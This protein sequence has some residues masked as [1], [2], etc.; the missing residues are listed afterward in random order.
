M[1]HTGR[2]WKLQVIG[3]LSVVLAQVGLASWFVLT[4]ASSSSMVK[5]R[6][7]D[8]SL[9]TLL[10]RQDQEDSRVVPLPRHD[11]RWV[12]DVHHLDHE[13]DRAHLIRRSGTY[14]H[15]YRRSVCPRQLTPYLPADTTYINPFQSQSLTSSAQ[16][17]KCS[18][19]RFRRRSPSRCWRRTSGRG[20]SGLRR[21][22][23]V[24]FSF[25]PILS[26]LCRTLTVR[27]LYGG[28]RSSPRFST[29][30]RTCTPSRTT[31]RRRRPTRGRSR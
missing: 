11:A 5:L 12:R 4:L 6:A 27:L 1:R 26:S 13:S 16:P 18:A 31:S 22:R 28:F 8:S 19:S 30:R 7:T 20:S 15:G 9:C 24:T 2:Y 29:R 10:V 25:P 21:T 23:C 14:C 3:T 17:A